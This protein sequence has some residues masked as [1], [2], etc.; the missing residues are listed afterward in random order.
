MSRSS[1]QA[2]LGLWAR[3]AMRALTLSHKLTR[4]LTH[5][6]DD[7]MVWRRRS[8]F[9]KRAWEQAANDAGAS[10]THFGTGALEI[11]LGEQRL[12]VAG[13]TTSLDDPVTLRIAGDKPLVYRLLDEHGVPVPNHVVCEGAEVTAA[14]RLA[15]SLRRPLV[16]KPAR[17]TG[18]G[19]G[20]TTGV[21]GVAGLAN[22]LA[23]AASYGDD[24]IIEE[25]LAGD[26]YRLLYLDG[27]LLDAVRR[28]P[29][30]VRGDGHHTVRQLI[31]AENRARASG[32]METSQTLLAIDRDLRHTLRAQGM[33]L[34]AVPGMGQVVPLKT[35]IND[36]RRDDNQPATGVLCEAI[37][38]AGATAAGA[39]GAR[40]AGIDVITPDP[41]RPLQES[42]G[43]IIEVN[44]TPGHYHHYT[45]P[46]DP[47][48][49]ARMILQRLGSEAH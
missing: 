24:A 15:A 4:R 28:R 29:P 2:A 5:R 40:L 23:L 47:G 48:R 42:G 6:R 19:H 32:G 21:T 35:V 36:N 25:Q 30:V 10:V 45:D 7:Q 1:R 31:A 43:A 16:V 33:R 18:S 9:Y 34:R 22:A 12:L 11:A 49:V 38:L 20:V 39:V 41:A 27:E 14:V 13:N 17:D 3:R 46:A 37:V 8:D 26:N 44:T